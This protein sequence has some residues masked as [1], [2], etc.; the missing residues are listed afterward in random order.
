LRKTGEWPRGVLG[1]YQGWGYESKRG[2]EGPGEETKTE[3]SIQDPEKIPASTSAA[4]R[5][6]ARSGETGLILK[7]G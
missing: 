4:S 2:H 7:P 1:D 5:Q 6:E 3:F